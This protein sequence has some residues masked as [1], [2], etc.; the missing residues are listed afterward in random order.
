MLLGIPLC[1]CC[2]LALALVVGAVSLSEEPMVEPGNEPKALEFLDQCVRSNSLGP[3]AD[4]KTHCHARGECVRVHRGEEAALQCNCDIGFSG[5][6]CEVDNTG[7]SNEPV[8][9]LRLHFTHSSADDAELSIGP[10]P[11]RAGPG[12]VIDPAA[13]S[14]CAGLPYLHIPVETEAMCSVDALQSCRFLRR[15]G[16]SVDPTHDE[17]A[18]C[19]C[20]SAESGGPFGRLGSKSSAATPQWYRIGNNGSLPLRPSGYRRCG[21]L[22][23]VRADRKHFC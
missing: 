5:D 3:P 18:L 20:D 1:G 19:R 9:L 6:K 13:H 2:F 11:V 7:D 10:L 8:I 14:M 16:D 17:R 21:T 4:W 22:Y 23:T 12:A 15:S